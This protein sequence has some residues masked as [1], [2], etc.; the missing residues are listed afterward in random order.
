MKK[1]VIKPPPPK[2]APKPEKA[3][4]VEKDRAIDKN[5]NTR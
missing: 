5:Y 3:P 4:L 2:P 1:K